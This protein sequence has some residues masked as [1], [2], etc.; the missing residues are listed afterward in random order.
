[1]RGLKKNRH[2]AWLPSASA[3]DSGYAPFSCDENGGEEVAP[4]AAATS[5]VGMDASW[6]WGWMEASLRIRALVVGGQGLGCDNMT[7]II[8]R[9]K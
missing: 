1:M 7:A 4:G 8:V 2:N 9:L 5:S 6:R 3:R